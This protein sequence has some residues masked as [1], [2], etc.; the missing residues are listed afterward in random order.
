[1]Q[2]NRR[3]TL[4]LSANVLA[5]WSKIN[6]TAAREGD[7]SDEK[8]LRLSVQQELSP[9][10][11]VSAGIQRTRFTTTVV[12]DRSYDATLGFIGMSHRF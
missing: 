1:M 11:G 4:Q 2:F 6:G 3:L 9:R 5:R 10:T 8:S 7:V 12:G